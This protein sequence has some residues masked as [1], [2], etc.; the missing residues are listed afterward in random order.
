MTALRNVN[1]TLNKKLNQ[2][3]FSL[4]KEPAFTEMEEHWQD[5]EARC[6]ELEAALKTCSTE[7]EQMHGKFKACATKLADE[8]SRTDMLVAG[9]TEL[10]QKLEQLE[11]AHLEALQENQRLKISLKA[12]QIQQ[13]ESALGQYLVAQNDE[14]DVQCRRSEVVAGNHRRI[15]SLPQ[16]LSSLKSSINPMAD[17]GE[18]QEE[19]QKDQLQED[20]DNNRVKQQAENHQTPQL[21]AYKQI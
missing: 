8:E 6:Q 15:L 7:L 1:Q 17:A 20:I 3:Y 9:N 11:A 12:K 19:S 2:K 16:L 14:R 13:D 5:A 18:S 4:R 21:A 10:K